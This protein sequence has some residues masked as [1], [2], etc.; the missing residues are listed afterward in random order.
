MEGMKIVQ[1]LEDSG[2]LINGVNKTIQNKAKE[3][4]CGFIET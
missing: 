3:Q 1:S 2:F 4:K